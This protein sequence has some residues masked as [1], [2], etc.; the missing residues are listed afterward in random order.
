MDFNSAVN[1]FTIERLRTFCKIAE[2]GSIVLAA[3]GN[4]T[5][6]SQF[7]RQAKELE[8]FFGMKLLERV[9]KTV[10]LTENGRKVALL[11]QGYFHSIEELMA[12]ATGEKAVRIGA[13]ESILRW[14]I[15]PRIAELQNMATAARFEFVTRPTLQSVKDLK[16]GRID[17][18]IIRREAVDNSLIVRSCGS[19]DY[20][21]VVPRKLLPGRTAAGF[22][23]LQ[24]IPFA[25]LTGDGILAKGILALAAKLN[26]K[27]DIRLWAEN[28]SLL[29]SAI[30]NADLAAVLPL[31][32]IAEIS[33][34]RFAI[35]ETDR[36]NLLTRELVIAYSPQAAAL[37]ENIRRIAPRISALLST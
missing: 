23:L 12:G 2:A 10:K 24:K 37:R 22:Q 17:L 36:V 11:T 4:P 28:F 13:G 15:M 18:A 26:V 30:E 32:A 33:K 27:L 21:L 16:S 7:S 29:V 20:A 9:G 3:K 31:P 1:G 14:V 34:E 35:I 6:Q 5:R 25:L 8:D 19:L